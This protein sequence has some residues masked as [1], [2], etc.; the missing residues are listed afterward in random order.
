ML[1]EKIRLRNVLSFGPD[2]PELT[3][4]PL[5]VLIGPN[6]SGK[7]NFIE[8]I[9]LLQAAPRDVAIPIR[10]GGGI[11]DWMWRGEPKA[12]SA[13]IE[14]ILESPRGTQPLR[15]CFGFAEGGSVSSWSRNGW[16]MRI[17]IPAIRSRTSTMNCRAPA[18][19]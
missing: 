10:E 17:R 8:A 9:G 1:I 3:L 14:A 6:G 7:S 13:R 19:P 11:F 16:R 15:Y 5:N 12:P 4:G 2:A 18:R